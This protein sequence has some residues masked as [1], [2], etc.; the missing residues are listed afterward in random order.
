MTRSRSISRSVFFGSGI[1]S[2]TNVAPATSTVSRPVPN[3]PTQKNGI[4]IYSLVSASM[5]RADKPARTAV[6]A[7]PCE[8][9]TPFGGPLLPEV[10]ITSMGSA[11]T[12][13]PASASTSA[14]A[15]AD[16]SSSASQISRKATRFASSGCTPSR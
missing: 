5:R 7:L 3:P 4:G 6:S 11:G 9:I 1:A 2:V 10:N 16:G 14:A 12:T 13:A 8:W 15:V